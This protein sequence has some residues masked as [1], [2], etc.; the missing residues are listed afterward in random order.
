MNILKF[1]KNFPLFI[2]VKAILMTEKA[3]R[4]SLSAIAGF[5]GLLLS[6]VAKADDDITGMINNVLN[7]V[8]SL[9]EPIVKACLVI[10]MGFIATGIVCMSAKK[11]NPQIKATHII[12]LFV[13]GAGLIALEQIANRSQKQMGLNPVSIG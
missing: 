8:Y 12:I 1:M 2:Y 9:K 4:Y 7:G 3:R 11:N 6:P 5:I 10:G 13:V